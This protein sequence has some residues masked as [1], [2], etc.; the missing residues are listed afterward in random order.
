MKERVRSTATR[1]TRSRANTGARQRV[2]RGAVVD[3]SSGSVTDLDVDLDNIEL[4][5]D[6]QKEK[7]EKKSM[8]GFGSKSKQEKTR[9]KRDAQKSVKTEEVATEP[10]VAE[11]SKKQTTTKRNVRHSADTKIDVNAEANTDEQKGNTYA[12]RKRRVKEK[13]VA[14]ETAVFGVQA[15]EDD[16]KNEAM[17]DWEHTDFKKFE[18]TEENLDNFKLEKA[19]EKQEN[20]VISAN[21]SITFGEFV[22]AEATEE[23][24][25]DAEATAD[26]EADTVGSYNGESE[27]FDLLNEFEVEKDT[28]VEQEESQPEEEEDL[29][30]KLAAE[31]EAETEE[32]PTVEMPKETQAEEIEAEAEPEIEMPKVEIPK[33]EEPKIS[34]GDDIIGEMAKALTKY[35]KSD[36]KCESLQESQV[37]KRDS[38]PKD[39]TGVNNNIMLPVEFVV[40]N[41]VKVKRDSRF[42]YRVGKNECVIDT[43]CRVLIPADCMFKVELIAFAKEKYGLELAEP[44]VIRPEDMDKPIRV[45][46]NGLRSDSYIP[47]MQNIVSLILVKNTPAIA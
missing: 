38:Q 44:N 39:V 35:C 4:F 31:A 22:T 8:F 37:I 6:E 42:E 12:L 18:A 15:S 17:I 33:V 26:V 25:R 16:D 11:E 19:A 41:G 20:S 23:E 13:P 1:E 10:S 47:D 5:A 29:L 7:K 27:F 14:E 2:T 45:K 43:G 40:I 9:Q 34:Y 24:L 46:V 32:L 28:S 3:E 21:S 30:D 36:L